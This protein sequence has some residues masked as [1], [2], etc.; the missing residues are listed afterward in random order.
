M[1]EEKEVELYA[2]EKEL[3]FY[4][5][6]FYMSKSCFD[7]L[8]EVEKMFIMKEHENKLVLDATQIRNAV[9]NAELNANRKKGARFIELFKKKQEKADVMFNQE[10][11][12]TVLKMEEEQ[13]KDWVQR[14]YDANN[15]KKP[16]GRDRNG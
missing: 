14:I 6:N 15:L 3:A 10:G 4:V 2:Y 9:L 1:Q 11:I 7:S 12:K 13:G 8:T 5:V 16:E